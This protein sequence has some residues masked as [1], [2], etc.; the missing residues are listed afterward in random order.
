MKIVFTGGGTGGHF[1]P[2]ISIAQ[3][4]TRIVKE[5]KLITPELYFM[6]PD[7]YNR[8]I[9]FDNAIEYKSVVS[10]K[11]RI[12]R[13]FLNFTD[14]F[15][16]AFG[17]LQA[18]WKLF[19]L[20]P[21]VIFSKGG[22]GSVPVV[23]AGKILGIPIIIHESDSAPG[24]AN[25]WAGKFATKIALSYPEA[26][27]YFDKKKV[28]WTGNPVR[29]QLKTPALEGGHQFL[30]FDP[31]IKTVFI[32]GGSSGAEFINN[33]VLDVLPQL[34][35][36][37]QVIHQTGKKLFKEVKETSDLILKD[38]Q[39]SDR[40]KIFPFLNDLAMRMSSGASDL[41]ISRAGSTIFEIAT[42]GRPSIIVPITESNNDHQRKNAYHYAR[43]GACIVIEENNLTPEILMAEIDRL[44]SS[45]ELL[46][47]M[48][49]SAKGFARPDSARLIA[50][51]IIDTLI[52]HES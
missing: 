52:D 49:E 23:F 18:L 51:E 8:G 37:Y 21:D 42:W 16:I 24:R 26:E 5:E 13:S 19:I 25:M 46:K 31:K 44:F 48:S 39:Y 2:I 7:P 34:L 12:Y 10:G 47:E 33:A 40:Y 11:K 28:A 45:P 1:Y 29:D 41:V 14:K 6:A 27:N 35:E 20:Y 15:K 9:L 50:K 17:I 36:K 32:L 38:S 3:E 43:T 4:I 30:N 22:W